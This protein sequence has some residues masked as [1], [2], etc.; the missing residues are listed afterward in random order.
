M[1]KLDVQPPA[2]VV[3]PASLPDLKP[4]PRLIVLVPDFEAD[5]A[6]VAQKIHSAAKTLESRVQLI[7]LSKDA[8]NEPSVRRRLVS[9]SAMVADA[10]I[11]VESKVEIGNNWLNAVSPHW[12][13]GDVIV[14]F[15]EQ[16]AGFGNKPLHQIL[17][18]NLNA[19]IYVLS[20]IQIKKEQSLPHWAS[21][22]V[23][24]I[25]SVGLILGFFWLQVKLSQPPQNWFHTALI[26]G[27]LFAEAGSIWVW[28]NLFR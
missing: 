6:L 26:Y 14:C 1:K 10:A 17:Q 21:S 7:G 16:N 12:R 28:N 2:F 22:T 19:T 8:M 15:A 4:A 23:A 13:Q 24:W 3:S 5:P 11:F 25:G 20:G 27:S 18:S 9:L